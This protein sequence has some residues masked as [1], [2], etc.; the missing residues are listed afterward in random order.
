MAAE[1][2]HQ[3]INA[4]PVATDRGALAITVSIGVT[5]YTGRMADLAALLDAADA[6]MY[7]AKRAGRDCVILQEFGQGEPVEP[8]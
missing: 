3:A 2:L 1:R 7:A 8:A 4:T 5:Q 6:A